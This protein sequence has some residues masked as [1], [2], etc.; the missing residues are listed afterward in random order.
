MLL[1]RARRG[2]VKPKSR[3]Q[4]PKS[5]LEL[6]RSSRGRLSERLES[7]KRGCGSGRGVNLRYSLSQNINRV[8]AVE[9]SCSKYLSATLLPLCAQSTDRQTA[10]LQVG[11]LSL[12]VIS[13]ASTTMWRASNAN[14]WIAET[15]PLCH[16]S[17]QRLTVGQSL[18]EVSKAKAAASRFK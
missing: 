12:Q 4:T 5:C 14:Q 17:T 7:V 10:S 16:D 8:S 6:T 18:S 1:E 2:K 15:E 13:R 3:L 11:R 9:T